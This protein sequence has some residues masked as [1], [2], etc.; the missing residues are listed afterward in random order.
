LALLDAP[1][2]SETVE[3]EQVES[4]LL[5]ADAGQNTS[6]HWLTE[7]QH[8]AQANLRDDESALIIEA[9]TQLVGRYPVKDETTGQYRPARFGDIMLLVRGRSHLA[10]YER[11]LRQ[12]RVPFVSSKR[13]GLL[14]TLE[15]LDLM[16]L[17]RWLIRLTAMALAVG[18]SGLGTSGTRKP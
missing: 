2:E 18:T 8:A 16:A 10:G 14:A 5:D 3:T 17:L 1:L 4:E 9:I 6:R 15:A 13:G 11:L 12:A 7:P